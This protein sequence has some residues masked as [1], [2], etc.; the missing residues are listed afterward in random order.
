MKD[1]TMGSKT[2]PLSDV[3]YL[4][5]DADHVDEEVL[6]NYLSFKLHR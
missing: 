6:K 2:Y 1:G 3:P 4:A 5:P